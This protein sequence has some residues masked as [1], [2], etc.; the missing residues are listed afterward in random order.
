MEIQALVSSYVSAKVLGVAITAGLGGI[1]M[2]LLAGGRS[3][4][5]SLISIV[6]TV[7]L[8]LI[9]AYE[10]GYKYVKYGETAN[11]LVLTGVVFG[12]IMIHK[13]NH[14]FHD[15]TPGSEHKEIHESERFWLGAIIV[16]YLGYVLWVTG[17]L[18]KLLEFAAS[19]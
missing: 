9:M 14:A 3:L 18:Q 12:F 1:V 6:L 15:M 11:L 5:W 19:R 17:L 16:G 2:I 10:M 4:L 8:G 7:V 13:A